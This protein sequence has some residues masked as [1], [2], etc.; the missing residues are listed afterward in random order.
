M[1]SFVGVV[2][3]VTWTKAGATASAFALN[4][5]SIS[6]VVNRKILLF[7]FLFNFS[8]QILIVK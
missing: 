5:M 6:A 3:A 4:I 1:L 2:T 8:P 7:V